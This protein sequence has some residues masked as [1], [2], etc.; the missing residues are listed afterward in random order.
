MPSAKIIPFPA[1]PKARKRRAKAAKAKTQA[2]WYGY[3]ENYAGKPS[4]AYDNKLYREYEGPEAGTF[5]DDFYA[6]EY[7]FRRRHLAWGWERFG[8]G[9]RRSRHLKCEIEY[10]ACLRHIEDTLDGIYARD[11]EQFYRE[12]AGNLLQ[13][14]LLDIGRNFRGQLAKSMGRLY[15]ELDAVREAERAKIDAFVKRQRA[16]R[17]DTTPIAVGTAALYESLSP[18]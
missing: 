18:S 1:K 14:F 4:E 17:G 8:G 3:S 13:A 2:K 9:R 6:R 7:Y 12:V 16:R 11:V 5:S 15:N 10:R